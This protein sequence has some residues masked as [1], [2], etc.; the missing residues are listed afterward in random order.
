M[1][2]PASPP[3]LPAKLSV[4]KSTLEKAN[5][6]VKLQANLGCGPNGK[7]KKKG[8]HAGGGGEDDDIIIEEENDKDGKKAVTCI[9]T[10]KVY[11]IPMRNM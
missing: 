7:R 8:H 10:K 1:Q 6:V 4:P 3:S 5:I 2:R 9:T 11:E